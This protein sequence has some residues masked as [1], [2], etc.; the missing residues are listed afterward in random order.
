MREVLKSICNVQTLAYLS[1]VIDE[2]VPLDNEV[3]PIMSCR[4]ISRAC[5]CMKADCNQ[6]LIQLFRC[7]TLT[8]TIRFGAMSRLQNFGII[9]AYTVLEISTRALFWLT[10][11]AISGPT[12]SN[13]GA[14]KVW[15]PTQNKM[16]A[17]TRASGRMESGTERV[18]RYVRILRCDLILMDGTFKK[19]ASLCSRVFCVTKCTCCAGCLSPFEKSSVLC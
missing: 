6:L 7:V 9:A 8:H 4:H 12:T 15:A 10:S 2:V 19:A 11:T 16:A 1:R 13:S 17:N 5:C 18:C 3:S 14:G